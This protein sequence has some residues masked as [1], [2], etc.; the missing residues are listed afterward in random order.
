MGLGFEFVWYLDGKWYVVV[1]CVGL[2]VCW[3]GFDVIYVGWVV[4]SGGLGVRCFTGGLGVCVVGLWWRSLGVCLS[5][6][7]PR[8]VGII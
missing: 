2:V 1:V 3:F 6:C 5:C 8:G 7:G 4:N